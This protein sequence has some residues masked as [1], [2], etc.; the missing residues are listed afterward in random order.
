M[1]DEKIVSSP[2]DFLKLVIGG[3]VVVKLHSG[4]DY[5]GRLV[6]LDGYMNIA[7]C[8]AEEWLGGVRMR[9]YGDTFIRGNNG[10]LYYIEFYTP[11]SEFASNNFR[12]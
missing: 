7:M 10:K 11:S 2:A 8:E 6:C 5:Y 12:K 3:N 1:D 4:T 9:K